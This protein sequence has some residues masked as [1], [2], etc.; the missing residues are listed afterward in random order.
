[1][2]SYAE[3]RRGSIQHRTLKNIPEKLGYVLIVSEGISTE[4]N[5]FNGIKKVMSKDLQRKFI[6][7]PF[8][9]G[10]STLQLVYE[11]IQIR[12][13]TPNATE[14]WIVLDYD[15]D[16]YFDQA[17]ELACSEGFNIAWSNPCFEVWLIMYLSNSERRYANA[18]ECKQI[19]NQYYQKKLQKNYEE[20]DPNIFNDMKSIG[21]LKQAI[22]V[23]KARDK[24]YEQKMKCDCIKPSQCNNN[25]KVYHLIEK[26]GKVLFNQGIDIFS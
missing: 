12:S 1:M 15:N 7:K 21:S 6:I 4:P 22:L 20:G 23:A 2:G 26:I 9:T 3:K 5:Y 11:A 14:T 8:G 18:R 13:K 24:Y 10:K 16:I 19:M 17:I 25:T